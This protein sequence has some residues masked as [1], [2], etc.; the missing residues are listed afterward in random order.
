[1]PICVTLSLSQL[2]FKTAESGL[3]HVPANC[4]LPRV[5]GERS[6]CFLPWYLCLIEDDVEQPDASVTVAGLG[7]IL[8]FPRRLLSW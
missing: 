2:P 7:K 4:S 8:L 3:R 5:L 6:V 1:M